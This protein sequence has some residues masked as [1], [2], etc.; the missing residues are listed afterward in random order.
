TAEW[1][2]GAVEE[3]SHLVRTPSIA[4][5]GY[6]EKPV[7]E[8]A[9]ATAQTLEAAGYGGDRLIAPPHRVPPVRSGGG[10][11]PGPRPHQPPLGAPRSPAGVTQWGVAMP[12]IRAGV[13]RRPPLRT[14]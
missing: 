7:R 10:G 5:P 4:F 11:G 14:G 6:D 13:S 8:A 2:P 9:E 3:L 12:S 1:P